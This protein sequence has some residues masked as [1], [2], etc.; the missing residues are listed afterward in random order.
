MV[1]KIFPVLLCFCF[2]A[3]G[4]SPHITNQTRNQYK[5]REI[6]VIAE[7]GSAKLPIII[8][9]NADNVVKESA[10]ELA[11]YL[12]K[13]TGAKFEI[14]TNQ[15]GS[16][17]FLGTINEFPTI[18]A[19]EGLKI[20]DIF[21]GKEAYA[22]RTENKSIKLLGAT[23]MGASY[24]AGRFLELIGCRF[25]FQSPVWTVVP[26]VSKITF[27]INETDRPEVL[28]R[29]LG[30]PLST[31][32]EKDDPDAGKLLRDWWRHNRVG[33]SLKTSVGHCW[34]EIIR[35]FKSEFDAHPEYLAMVD[36]KRRGNQLCVSNPEVVN[37]AIKYVRDY[38]D[39]H[40]DADMIGV[41]P[42]D[43]G[44]YCGCPECSKKWQNPGDMAFYLANEVAKALQESHP[45]KMVG[46]Y[47]YNWHCDPPQ[48]NLEPNVYVELTTALLLNTK[49]GFDELLKLWPEKCKYFGLYD[50][51]AVYDWIRD[52]LPSGRTGNTRYVAEKLP[53]YMK[54]GICN[55]SAESGN[56]WGSQGLGY[57]LAVR[58]LWNSKTDVEALK[59]DFY[60]KAFGPAQV[61]MKRY[62]ERIDLGNKPLT[63][64]TFYRLCI[65]DLE[66]A[67]KLAKNNPDVL[68]RIEQLKQYHVFLY[69]YRK[70]YDQK[71]LTKEER[72][73]WALEMLKWNYR[74]RNTYM[75]FWSFFAD[76]TTKKLSDEFNEPSWWWWKMHSEKKENEIPYRIKDSVTAEETN[77]WLEI[78]KKEYGEPISF[79]EINFSKKLVSPIWEGSTVKPGSLLFMSQG[80]FDIALA[81][82]QGEPLQLTIVHGTI[83][84]NFPDGK[85]TLSDNSGKII[86]ENRVPYGENK[87]SLNVP[88][89]GVYT[90][91]YD[92]FAAGCQL[93]PSDK[94]KT[95]F[96]FSKGE[97]FKVYNHNYLYFYVPKG[98]KEICFYA[99]R[100]WPI[101]ICQPDGVWVG[102]DKPIYHHPRSIKADGSYQKISVPEGMDGKIWSC[103]DFLSGSF[104]FFN[105]PNILFVRPSDVI[106]PEDVAKKDGL[107][108]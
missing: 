45:G 15:S 76:Q 70:T 33:K 69:F 39:K 22:I 1:K 107:K 91:K 52:R 40:P 20:Y 87:I 98:T 83:Y 18:S 57:Y 27:N 97:S 51:W 89:S 73:N 77:K 104:Y 108:F 61:P 80:G 90:M 5:S 36:G 94:T 35:H 21:D 4:F 28:S 79:K 6:V 93:I 68:A 48:F 67:E 100:S 103:V 85:Y 78:A 42:D 24:A 50:Y 102:E 71:E 46:I 41:G 74:I 29:Y 30:Y 65:S 88:S 62:Y 95:A 53:Y 106:V 13:I 7:N 11:F 96:I 72:K 14:K 19:S 3:Y 47:A 75:T 81:S 2:A 82:L 17:I 54:Y 66:E 25:F 8:S 92:D 63:G 99:L 12:E 84:K 58:V 26:K 23:S 86:I 32:F 55:L 64:P 105:I 16:G 49:Y 60:E 38:F 31:S 101:G 34:P 59:N 44:G 9:E 43:G 10:N 37:L 56:S